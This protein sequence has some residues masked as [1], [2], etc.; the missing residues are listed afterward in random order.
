MNKTMSTLRPIVLWL[1]VI[2]IVIMTVAFLNSSR[3]LNT[4]LAWSCLTIFYAMSAVMF[5][6]PSNILKRIP[7]VISTEF[8]FTVFFYILF[9]LPYQQHLLGLIDYAE[10]SGIPNT[11]PEQ[12][13]RAIIAATIAYAAFQF[14]TIL[15]HIPPVDSYPKSPESP[16]RYLWIDI[17]L[18]VFLLIS[19]VSYVFAGFQPA[20]TSRYQDKNF[21]GGPIADGL[22][23][24]ILTLCLIVITRVIMRLAE[25]R[26]LTAFQIAGLIVVLGWSI[27]IL[28]GGDRNNFLVIAL[29]AFG[30]FAAL[31]R[32][33][34]FLTVVMAMLAAWTIY[35]VVEVARR[36]QN[37]GG[38]SAFVTQ[39]QNGYASRED[40]ESS[41]NNST[42]A[43]RVALGIVPNKEPFSEG[44]FFLLGV[45]GILPLARGA[46]IGDMQH[47]TTS[48][49]L[50]D[51]A[52][53][54][55]ANWG[56]G[57]T[58]VSDSY[59]NFGLPGL[60]LA[61]LSIGIMLSLIRRVL[62]IR[63][64]TTKSTFLFVSAI[65]LIGEIPRYPL[66]FPIRVIVWGIFILIIFEFTLGSD[67]RV[68]K[69]PH[70]AN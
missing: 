22:Y 38:F 17:F 19:C 42:V 13:N 33:V 58:I 6:F 66:H 35:N 63:G 60:I 49:L 30:G 32:P 26:R 54:P 12:G 37:E 40:R 62:Q 34:K 44:K 46:F 11:Y 43:T 45:A 39:I 48:E 3:G 52:L 53:G 20:D 27:H 56:V 7:L 5:L 24:I 70:R 14:G 9:Y 61:P 57:T 23:V 1:D 67:A 29:S 64:L 55:Q 31:V 2:I 18:P 8:A 47:N 41:F 15:F 16:R 25:G 21:A 50:S 36:T 4:F 69:L 51:Y 10:S 28:A 68:R 65:G 59:I